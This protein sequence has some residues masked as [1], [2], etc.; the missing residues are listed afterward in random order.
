MIPAK[1]REEVR[2]RDGGCVG[3]RVGMPGPCFGGLETHHVR[4]GGFGMKGPST[5]DNLTRLCLSHHRL[6]TE[7]SKTWRPRLIAYLE[8]LVS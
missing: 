5:T 3:P 1:V 7:R 4:N 2:D 8:S 6:A